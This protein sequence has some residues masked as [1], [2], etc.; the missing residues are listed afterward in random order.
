MSGTRAVLVGT[1]TYTGGLSQLDWSAG[2]VVDL[3]DALVEDY[4]AGN[5]D[6]LVDPPTAQFVLDRL[7]LR[8]SAPVDA[9]VF[10]YTG[11]GLRDDSDR[12]CLA[13]PGSVDEEGHVRRTSLPVDSV[14]EIIARA[15]AAWKVVILDCCYSGLAMDAPAA[16]NLHLLTATH[17]TDKAEY[18]TQDRHTEFT[19]ELLAF[20]EKTPGPVDLGTLYRHLDHTLPGRGL[21]RP[22]QRCVNHSADFVLRS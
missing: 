10:Y 14:F 18:R 9:L 17:R 15:D 20:L 22:Q 3:H 21:P 1:S 8:T 7:T 11:H 19:G 2:N 12:L 13:L 5:L 6:V 16:A 4:G